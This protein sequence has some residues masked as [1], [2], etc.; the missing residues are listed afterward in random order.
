[1]DVWECDLLDIQ[2]YAKYNDNF[3]YILLVKN[4]FS[5]F[6]FLVPVKTKS[7]PAFTTAF[8]SIFDYDP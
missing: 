3:K 2:A 1:M 6:L 4:L 5:K 7:G 8:L